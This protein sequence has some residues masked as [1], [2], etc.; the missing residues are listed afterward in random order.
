[1]FWIKC[2]EVVQISIW[3]SW[4]GAPPPPP[5]LS[6]TS[7]FKLINIFRELNYK[8][9]TSVSLLWFSLVLYVIINVPEM[10]I[11]KV[12]SQQSS[13]TLSLVKYNQINKVNNLL[14]VEK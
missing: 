1:M 2:N 7:Q 6:Q 3:N 5:P 9:I 14:F 10:I 13:I 4:V 11:F 8:L 12:K